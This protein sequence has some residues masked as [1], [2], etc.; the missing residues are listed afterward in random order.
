MRICRTVLLQ[1]SLR[2]LGVLVAMKSVPPRGSVWLK[3]SYCDSYSSASHTLPRG[4]T[5]FIATRMHRF[6]RR[7]EI[8][9]GLMETP[10]ST[11]DILANQ[12]TII[13][14]QEKI[15]SNQAKLDRMLSNQETIIK[16]QTSILENQSKL[17][18]VVENQKR[19]LANQEAI[20]SRLS[21]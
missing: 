3:T 17:D 11:E 16:N 18:S 20:L 21:G 19:I 10:M 13:A 15:Q 8:Q 2:N 9:L 12:Q 5:D 6:A 7:E 14:N 1:S 4:G